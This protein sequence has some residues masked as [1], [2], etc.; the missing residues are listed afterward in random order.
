M[1][2]PVVLSVEGR[3]V[4]VVGGG[5]VARRKVESLTAAGA[6]VRLI[7]PELTPELARLAG[8]GEFE[9]RRSEFEPADLA[10]CWLV[11]AAT[12]EAGVNQRVAQAAEAATIWCNVVDQ[13]ADCSFIVPA[14]FRRGRLIVAVSTQGASPLLAARVRDRLAADF[15]P[16]WAGYVDLIGRARRAII[17]KG[18]PAEENRPLLAALLEADL[19]TPLRQG[20][21]TLLDE[22]L[23]QSVG[24]S[25]SQIEGGD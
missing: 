21:N 8:A 4:L 1:S 11:I 5:E 2:Y 22:R 9:W 15:D 19:L 7:A 6:K 16:A 18:R 25:L 23:R 20:D 17:K 3:L 10:G 13:P 12:D 14:I 24:L